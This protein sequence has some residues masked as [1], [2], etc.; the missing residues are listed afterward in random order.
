MTNDII[1]FQIIYFPAIFINNEPVEQRGEIIRWE[2]FKAKVNSNEITGHNR[3]HVHIEFKNMN[4][5]CTIDDV[6]EV[7][8]PNNVKSSIKKY[9]V[10]MMAFPNN[11]KLARENW[12]KCRSLCKFTKQQLNLNKIS[13]KYNDSKVYIS[14]IE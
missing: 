11:L 2:S 5:V 9:I 4:I 1:E 3:P 8:A 6:I 12:N 13:I 10:K 14:I 7:I